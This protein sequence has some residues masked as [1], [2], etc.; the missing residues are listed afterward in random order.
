MQPRH[1]AL[2]ILAPF[3]LHAEDASSGSAAKDAAGELFAARYDRAAELY[4]A[5]LHSDPAWGAGYYGSVRALIGARRAPEAYAAAEDGLRHAPDSAEGQTAAGLAAYR[6]GDLPHAEAYFRKAR[7]IDAHY[8]YAP[9]G[10]ASIY[11]AVSKFKTGQALAAQ[12]WRAAPSDPRLMVE[13]ASS[14]QGAEHIAALERAL[15]LYDP[16]SR[17]AVSLR[18]HIASDKAAGGR[19]L[20]R[21]VS[22]YRS[23]DVQLVPIGVGR[24]VYAVGLRVRFNDAHAVRLML[25]TGAGGISLSTKAAEKAGLESLSGESAEF[26]GLG[27]RKPQEAFAYLASSVSVGDIRF[28]DFPVEASKAADDPDYDGLIGADVF[29]QFQVTVDF[30]KPRLIL[31]PYSDGQPG[32]QALD[33]Q[34]PLPAGFARMFRFGHI[35]AVETSINQRPPQLFVVDSGWTANLI[36]SGAAQ[37]STKVRRDYNSGLTGLQGRLDQVSRAAKVSLIFAGFRQDNSDLLATSLEGLADAKGVSFAGILGM[38]VLW[39]M[40]MTIDYRAG[41]LRFERIGAGK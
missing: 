39:Q 9:S 5:L 30:Q 19:K 13:W 36:D 27:D 32:D 2:L 38:P 34:D 25:D 22:P 26:K 6:R 17:E 15:A 14:L 24:H 16:S 3:A 40:K 41:A 1:F 21:L 18:A 11:N 35:L 31:S 23:Y 33:A 29:R 4:S 7:E 12:A 10:L 37:E 8:A 20:R 28:A